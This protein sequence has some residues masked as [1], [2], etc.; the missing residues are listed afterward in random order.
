MP[1]TAVL[2]GILV[3]AAFCLSHASVNVPWIEPVLLWDADR[4]WQITT[5]QVS[6]GS[7]LEGESE[8]WATRR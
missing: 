6:P 2:S 3:I 8:D 5:L 4:K 1:P 7:T